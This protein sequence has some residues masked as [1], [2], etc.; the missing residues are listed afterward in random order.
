MLTYHL[1]PSTELNLFIPPDQKDQLLTHVLGVATV[2]A[3]AAMAD[4]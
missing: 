2:G 1:V 4:R 3:K